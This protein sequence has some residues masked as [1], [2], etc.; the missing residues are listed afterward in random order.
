MYPEA[1]FVQVACVSLPAVEAL[2]RSTLVVA[3]IGMVAAS[4]EI[5]FQTGL[6]RLDSGNAYMNTTE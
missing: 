5:R 2:D 3:E 1:G 6:H 4:M